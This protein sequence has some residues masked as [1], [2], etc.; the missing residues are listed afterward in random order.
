[1]KKNFDW[2]VILL[3]LLLTGFGIASLYSTT[4]HWSNPLWKKQ[5]VWA[6]V[7]IMGLIGASLINYSI[8]KRYA[9]LIYIIAIIL[10]VIVLFM[11]PIR[12]ARS[13]FVLPFFSFQ[14]SEFAKLSTIIMLSIYLKDK[15]GRF[16][17]LPSFLFPG[18]IISIPVFLILL[19]PDIGSSLI[20]FPILFSMLYILKPNRFIFYSILLFL[21][22]FGALVIFFSYLFFKGMNLKSI[23]TWLSIISILFFSLSIVYNHIKKSKGQ[24][25]IS[26]IIILSLISSLFVSTI[27]KDYQKK[28]LLVFLNQSFDPLGVGYNIT[29]SKI[30]I[31]GGGICG[32]GFLKGSQSH[33]GFLPEKAS[34]FIFSVYAEE[35]GFLGVFSL[36]FLLFLLIIM[37]L[38][39][40]GSCLD[41]FGSLL[42]CG[43][44]SMIAASAFINI[45][46]CCGILPVTGIPLPFIS[47]GGS[48]LFINMTS[49]GMLLSI[50]RWA[51]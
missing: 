43:I 50:K 42:A 34:D 5:L 19:Q 40:I 23:F 26:F 33:L 22:F 8:L 18:I 20:F 14:P 49:I 51:R 44:C 25:I 2:W 12:S 13:W 4:S 30:A 28:R 1:M 16:N 9:L 47:Y 10:L 31:G 36:L 39:I 21:L 15:A 45:A 24:M 41:P 38:N 11:P 48:S 6:F 35:F 3:V 17:S 46:I 32:T 37:G 27:L 29:Q 7:G